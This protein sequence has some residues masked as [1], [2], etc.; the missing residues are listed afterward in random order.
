MAVPPPLPQRPPP[1]PASVLPYAGPATP[2]DLP[3]ATPV[4]DYRTQYRPSPQPGA[5]LLLF[6]GIGAGLIGLAVLGGMVDVLVDTWP[7]FGMMLV[8]APVS[9]VAFAFLTVS[10]TAFNGMRTDTG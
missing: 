6:S 9:L 1:L 8:A 7:S 2:N 4:L 5:K 3:V 10:Y